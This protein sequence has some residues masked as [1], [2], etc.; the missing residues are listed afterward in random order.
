MER[1]ECKARTAKDFSAAGLARYEQ[2]LDHS[3]VL[4]DLRTWQAVPHLIENPRL[5]SHYPDAVT[6]LMEQVFTVGPGPTR[7]LM[8]T[9]LRGVRKDFL[10][11][12]TAKDANQFRKL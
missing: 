11:V 4:Q 3:F 6:R 2:Y 10:T 9:V 8:S 1:V 7:R 5:F 12:A